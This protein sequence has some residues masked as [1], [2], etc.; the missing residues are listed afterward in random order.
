MVQCL[1][2]YDESASHDEH[3]RHRLLE[4][5]GKF[6]AAAENPHV[7][8]EDNQAHEEP[9]FL[10]DYGEY[11]IREG[12]RQTG[13]FARLAD[14]YAPQA[15]VGLSDIA[16]LFLLVLPLAVIKD[17]EKASVCEAIRAQISAYFSKDRCE[18]IAKCII[19]GLAEPDD[20]TI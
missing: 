7:A 16:Q 4:A 1:K 15:A 10:N 18:R 9:Q 19:S 12:K 2:Y 13:V 8:R 20:Q 3:A 14:A 6:G 17:G 5:C 11:I